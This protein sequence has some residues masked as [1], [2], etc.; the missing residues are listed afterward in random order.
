MD[1][2]ILPQ[3]Y[4]RK[5]E[6]QAIAEFGN[7]CD[8]MAGIT[9]DPTPQS[10]SEPIRQNHAHI[11]TFVE[12]P[13][14]T[15]KLEPNKWTQMNYAEW[16]DGSTKNEVT[17]ISEL[18]MW[19]LAGFGPNISTVGEPN[20]SSFGN[21]DLSLY[22]MNKLKKVTITWKDFM[23][24]VERTS[25]G[26]IQFKDTPVFESY[27]APCYWNIPAGRSLLM[28]GFDGYTWPIRNSNLHKMSLPSGTPQIVNS[29]YTQHATVP[30]TVVGRQPSSGSQTYFTY[31]GTTPISRSF[32][33]DQGW[34]Y[35]QDLFEISSKLLADT[36]NLIGYDGFYREFG[37][38]L[39]DPG[40]GDTDNDS[41]FDE[42]FH[43]QMTHPRFS[44]LN[45]PNESMFIRCRNIPLGLTN[46]E[47]QLK[48]TVCISC[49]WEG[50][51]KAS[52]PMQNYLPNPIILQPSF[53]TSNMKKSVKRKS[54]E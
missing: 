38:W 22:A 31:D 26:G 44:R 17:T 11:T 1:E 29:M 41:T 21:L 2:S 36:E 40:I 19:L 33:I 50:M 42:A 39:K 45:F 30:H 32:T 27:V 15:I 28:A 37:E 8:T 51:Y 4:T 5:Y 54:I 23:W 7:D 20:M 46:V 49:E 10:V 6:A 35:A 13:Y 48:F 16:F 18:P 34:G 14:Q 25:A 12:M 9:P 3:E 24:M 47:V 52:T 53:F 43:H